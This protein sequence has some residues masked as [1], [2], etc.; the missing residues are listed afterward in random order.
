MKSQISL[1]KYYLEILN[2]RYAASNWSANTGDDTSLMLGKNK[3]QKMHQ[4]EL[5]AHSVPAE[6]KES[7]SRASNGRA[8]VWNQQSR[9]HFQLLQCC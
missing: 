8:R 6:I 3:Y 2:K 9:L 5:T 7:H 1:L 4:Q